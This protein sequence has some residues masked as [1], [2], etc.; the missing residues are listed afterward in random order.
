VLRANPHPTDGVN[1]SDARSQVQ[2]LTL[3]L[4]RLSHK[5]SSTEDA[6]LSKTTELIDVQA[7]VIK[8]KAAADSAYELGARV[9][10]REEAGLA[11]EHHLQDKVVQLEED[12]RI[13]DIALKEY[14]ALV[15]EMETTKSTHVNGSSR[16]S[17]DVDEGTRISATLLEGQLT[18]S[19]LLAQFEVQTAHLEG[20]LHA[21]RTEL[22]VT[23]SL[24][25][26]EKKGT[27][28][29]VQEL[30]NTKLALE[31]LHL[32]DGTAAKMVSRYMY[33]FCRTTPA[34]PHCPTIQAIFA[35][36]YQRPSF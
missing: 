33:V 5:L 10:G 19:R 30:G 20:E 4:R 18:R 16:K 1:D 31:K 7:Q 23:T 6:L 12:A 9:R 27:A 28:A 34:T 21:A 29:L 3:A 13:M 2:D 22:E 25:E 26:A 24:L 35:N 14:A 11:R 32:E 15:R 8:A 17:E 36:S